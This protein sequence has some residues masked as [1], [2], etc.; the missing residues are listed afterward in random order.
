[1][2]PAAG[3]ASVSL[4][5]G[6][7]GSGKTTVLNRLV[8]HP[9]IGETAIIVNEFGEISIDHMLV[10][11]STE[12]MIVLESG[13]VCCSVRNDLLETLNELWEKREAGEIPRFE[14][15][16]IET[17][18]LADPAP[19]LKTLIQDPEMQ[20]HYWLDSVVATVDVVNGASTLDTNYESVK[21]VAVADRLLLTKVDL[22]DPES[23]EALDERLWD[24]NASAPHIRV[25]A[26]LSPEVVFNASLFHRDSAVP[27]VDGWLRD[28]AF[29]DLDPTATPH[30]HGD[31]IRSFC[32]TYDEPIPVAVFEAWL[33][34][35]VHFKGP[36]LL[37]VKGLVALAEL[38]GPAVI[39]FVQHAFHPPITLD[40]WPT[41]DR[42]TRVVFITRGIEK[43]QIVAALNHVLDAQG[44]I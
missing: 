6:F 8:Q 12:A 27:D 16:V 17:T 32:L 24:L 9:D 1:M 15:V 34:A 4:L 5:T 23:V 11:T 39:H 13:C 30:R 41:S 31:D 7:L 18:G 20:E 14:R 28:D 44:T 26:D 19:I 36:D 29:E 10:E 21:Q 25:D 33:T 2:G 42:R 35:L 43:S 22:A 3:R 38:D 37:R 40:A